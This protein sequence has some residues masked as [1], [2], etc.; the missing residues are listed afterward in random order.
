[1]SMSRP[2]QLATSVSCCLHFLCLFTS[3]RAVSDDRSTEVHFLTAVHATYIRDV[4]EDNMVE[5]KARSYWIKAT[6]AYKILYD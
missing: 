1:M 2:D 6:Y 3:L 4:F 5:A